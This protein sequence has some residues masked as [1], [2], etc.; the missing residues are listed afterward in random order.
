MQR[1][2]RCDPA[3]PLAPKAARLVSGGKSSGAS[4]PYGKP[5]ARS[6]SES[7]VK[8]AG[9]GVVAPGLRSCAGSNPAW[10]TTVTSSRFD[11][12]QR[13]AIVR[14]GRAPVCARRRAHLV[15]NLLRRS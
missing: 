1:A 2:E 10:V 12:Y 7:V 4:P 3:V 15:E 13:D 6:I 9:W 14:A 8:S 11:C 5:D